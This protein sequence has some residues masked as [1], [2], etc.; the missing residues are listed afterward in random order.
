M[1]IDSSIFIKYILKSF[2]ENKK[3]KKII[4]DKELH[5]DSSKKMLSNLKGINIRENQEI[6]IDIIDNVLDKNKLT[7]IEAPT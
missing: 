4:V 3:N 6:M 1:L 2:P 5:I 7:L